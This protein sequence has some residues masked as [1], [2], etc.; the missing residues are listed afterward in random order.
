VYYTRP[1]LHTYR[2]S[3]NRRMWGFGS[4]QLC[5]IFLKFS[6]YQVN[7]SSTKYFD[8]KFSI[9]NDVFDHISIK[10]SGIAGGFSSL[11]ILE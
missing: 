9:T 5:K 3:I 6:C 11:G 1:S 8:T 10:K 7:P 2:L 4:N